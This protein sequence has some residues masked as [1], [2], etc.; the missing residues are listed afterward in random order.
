MISCGFSHNDTVR[1]NLQ[2]DGKI[3]VSYLNLNA[4]RALFPALGRKRCRIRALSL[5][6]N[7]NYALAY[8]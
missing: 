7:K 3:L 8:P 5:L 2:K 4:L 1:K 6:G